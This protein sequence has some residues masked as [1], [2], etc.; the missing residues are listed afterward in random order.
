MCGLPLVA[1]PNIIAGPSIERAEDAGVYK[2]S[3]ELA[4]V[5]SV[6]FFTPIV[7]D[8]FVFGQIAAANALSDLYAM[9]AR[10]LSALNIM[11]FPVA[12]MDI[13]VFREVVLGGLDKV[14]EAGA[15]LLGGHSID[16]PEMKYGLA[17]TGLAHPDKIVLNSSAQ[18]GDKIVLTKPIGTGI[19]STAVKRGEAT[20][21]QAKTV[22][23][24]MA[25]LNKSAAEAMLKVGASA[26]TDV[27]GFGLIGHLCEMMSDE[28]FGIRLEFHSVPFLDGALGFVKAKIAPG[29]LFRNRKFYGERLL[30]EGDFSKDELKLLFDPQTSG[31]LLIAVPGPRC[32]SLVAE[33]EAAG[34]GTFAVI[35][36]VIA[37]PISRIVLV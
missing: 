31:G 35:G 13:S 2:L 37:E 30:V 21:L 28:S 4:L 33:L 20:D 15:V 14:H 22:A 24:T 1:D 23:K 5:Q 8:P 3:D 29:G 17:V 19:V 7:D 16:D 6:D 10:P 32:E 12:K 27:T 26:C 34:V 9:G 36:E 11:A 25:T 18:V